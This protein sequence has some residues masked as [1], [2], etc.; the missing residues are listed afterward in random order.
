MPLFIAVRSLVRDLVREEVL[1][2]PPAS[3]RVCGS[4]A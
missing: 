1:K 3:N 2:S 4:L